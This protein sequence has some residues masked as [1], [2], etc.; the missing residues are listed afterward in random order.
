M[1]NKRLK[2]VF[3]PN[4][5]VTE[6][7]FT[8]FLVPPVYAEQFESDWW[9][10]TEKTLSHNRKLL[11]VIL[12]SDATTC[13]R[14]G[15][16]KMHPVYMS[17]GNIPHVRRQKKDAKCLVGY[18]PIIE[19]LPLDEI[20]S[21]HNVTTTRLR[22]AVIDCFHSCMAVLLEEFEDNYRNGVTLRQNHIS[23]EYEMRLSAIISDWPEAATYTLTYKAANSHHPCHTCSVTRDRLNAISLDHNECHLRTPREMKIAYEMN[24]CHKFSAVQKYNIF[25]EYQ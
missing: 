16:T 18:I 13:D 6:K 23:G 17:L 19:D 14:L 15:K 22:T 11:S 20:N 5:S 25:W 8:N 9:H 1:C 4:F 21:S 7:K 12:Y 2:N 10:D 24:Q 3:Q